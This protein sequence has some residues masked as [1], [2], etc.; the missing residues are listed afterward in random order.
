MRQIS[1]YIR[2][3]HIALLAL[4]VALGG[5]SYAAVSL[6]K[7]SVGTDQLKAR[8]VSTIKLAPG[9]VSAKRLQD[10]AVATSKLQDGAVNSEKVRDG[11]L[12]RSDF[13]S[14]QLP[15]GA[16]GP[17][18][19]A[20]TGSYPNPGIANGAVGPDQ[21][22]EIPSARLI[23]G[24][25][26]LTVPVPSGGAM[27][28]TPV[29]WPEPTGARPYD[30]GGFFNIADNTANNVC[31]TPPYGGADTC[32]VFPRTG[33]YAVSAGLRWATPPLTPGA[34]A[35]PDNGDGI[36]TLRIHGSAGRQAA[37]QTTPAADGTQTLQS[38]T[39]IDRFTAGDFA[40]VTAFQNSPAELVI[41]GSLQQVYF[42]ATWLGP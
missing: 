37:S 31:T 11:S 38:V 26:P 9:A 23:R 18:G 30:I 32:I 7:A 39:T 33:T 22:G 25:A 6:P 5:T 28:G 16:E 2:R 17:A 10:G 4:F 3:H 19:G 20:L 27:G 24:S 13:A 41:A 14:G 29:P 12:L 15:S 40:Y 21:F 8:S 1:R 35:G 36:R 34:P 42:A